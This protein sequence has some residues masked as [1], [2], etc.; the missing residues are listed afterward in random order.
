ML[1]RLRRSAW[2]RNH[3]AEELPL[4]I[5]AAA[6]KVSGAGEPVAAVGGDR[7]PDR[8]V[9]SGGDGVAMGVDAD[10]TDILRIVAG[11]VGSAIRGPA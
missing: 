6:A 5:V 11:L 8:R 10:K 2:L 7:L 3:A 1:P 9:G 4:R